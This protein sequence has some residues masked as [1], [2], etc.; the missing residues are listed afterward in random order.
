MNNSLKQ[1]TIKLS[2]SSDECFL[3]SM[4]SQSQL[5]D[6]SAQQKLQNFVI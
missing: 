2:D 6:E 5:K 3:D 1:N 4:L